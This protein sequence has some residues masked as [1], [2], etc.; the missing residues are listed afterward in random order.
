M[1]TGRRSGRS[2]SGTSSPSGSSPT[3]AGGRPVRPVRDAGRRAA[4]RREVHR[5]TTS[6]APRPSWP[7]SRCRSR[8]MRSPTRSRAGC[9]R[10]TTRCARSIASFAGLGVVVV[11]TTLLVPELGILGDP[12]RLC[13]RGDRQGRPAR[14]L[15]GAA[16]P[17]DRR[18][19]GGSTLIVGTTAMYRP[20]RDRVGALGPLPRQEVADH[21]GV[22]LEG[23]G[24]IGRAPDARDVRGYHGSRM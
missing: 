22:V 14:D 8:S 20:S 12:V 1:T 3:L 7:R 9:T 18:Q 6:R 5:R 23:S 19:P 11:A 10:R 17:A 21:L 16:R 4:R 13:G 24:R 2:W 15:P